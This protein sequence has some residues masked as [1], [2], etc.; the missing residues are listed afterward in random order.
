[1]NDWSLEQF[2]SELRKAAAARYSRLE[3]THLQQ[4]HG[5]PLLVPG[6]D[7][8]GSYWIVVARGK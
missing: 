8:E 2:E 5:G 6:R 4:L 1:L 3:L 7:P